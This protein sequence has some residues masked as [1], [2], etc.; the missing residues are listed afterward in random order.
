MKELCAEG[1]A[2][3]GDPKPCSHA[4]KGMG[5][6][7]AGAHAGRVLSREIDVI[8]S[9][10][11]VLPSGRQHDQQRKRELLVD[12]ARSARPLACVEPLCARTGRTGGRPRREEPRAATGRAQARSRR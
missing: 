2:T 5:E 6:A 7:S 12:S 10:D 9:A 11:A 8:R 4:R 3:H 1:S